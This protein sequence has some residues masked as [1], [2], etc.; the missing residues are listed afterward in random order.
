MNQTEQCYRWT[1][2]LFPDLFDQ[3]ITIPDAQAL[4]QQI[5]F[6]HGKDRAPIV[7]G[8]HS[9]FAIGLRHSIRLPDQGRVKP[10]VLHEVSHSLG[11]ND[12]ETVIEGWEGHGPQYM[13]TLIDLYAVFSGLNRDHMLDRADHFSLLVA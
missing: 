8:T 6:Y 13:K 9:R 2:D 1:Y 12:D 4:V 3:I 10:L 7:R 11:F 5:W